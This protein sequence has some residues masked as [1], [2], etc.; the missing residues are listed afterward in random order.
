M[1]NKLSESAIV[2]AVAEQAIRRITRQ[3]IADLQRMKDTLSG[4][5]SG[6]KTTWDEIC[7]QVQYEQSFSWDAYDETVKT[8][9]GGYVHDLPV[10][11]REAIWLQTEPGCNWDGEAPETRDAQPV[12]DDDITEYITNQH[13]YTEAERWSNA[14]IRSYLERLSR[15]D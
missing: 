1:N 3:V 15:R 8:F 5:G 13:L 2:E 14:R 7:V 9:V 6:L 4:E 12:V 11:E 10:H